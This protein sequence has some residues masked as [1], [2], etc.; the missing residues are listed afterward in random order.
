MFFHAQIFLY[1]L[2]FFGVLEFI[3]TDFVSGNLSSLSDKHFFFLALI[4]IGLFFYFFQISKKISRSLLM[5]PVPIFFV[6]GSFALLYFIQSRWQ[7]HFF[8]LIC[9]FVYY[10]IH[11]ALYRLRACKKDQTA[12]GILSAGNVATI[13]LIY[14]VAFGI[15]LNFAI[16][17]W[18]FMTVII[19]ITMTMGFQYFFL[20]N[21]DKM[22]VLSFSLI[23]A[24]IMAEL[25]WVLNFWPFGYLTTSVSALAFY[26][27]FWDIIQ[28]HFL[29]KLSKR[30][31]VA[32]MIFL[33]VIVAIVLSSTRWLPI[34]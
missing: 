31:I 11:I 8:I 2:A 22:T 26:F 9:A 7:Q 30:R 24:F 5:L 10:F 1:S 6:T 32:N 20:I 13:F 27:V 17:L 28:C 16:G 4:F 3:S 34:V 15:Y 25:I 23:L 33:G 19:I 21:D 18:F 29:Q 14:A 12:L